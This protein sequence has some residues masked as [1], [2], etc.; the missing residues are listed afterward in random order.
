MKK[1]LLLALVFLGFTT[2]S[3]AQN[4]AGR[5]Q[6][7]KIAFLTRKLDLSPEEAQKFWPVYNN[8]EAEI[9]KTRQEMRN[10]DDEIAFEEKLVGVRK[11]YR[12][13]FSKVLGKE[14]ANKVFTE[15]KEFNRYVQKEIQERR[16]ERQNNRKNNLR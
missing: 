2:V 9:R 13:E 12:E 6:A 16:I 4:P 10:Q 14:K 8:Y 15:E 11:K 7:L 1:I 3:L 5:V